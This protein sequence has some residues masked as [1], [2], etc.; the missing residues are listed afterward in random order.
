VKMLVKTMS[1]SGCR[2]PMRTETLVAQTRRHC[3][4]DLD[5]QGLKSVSACAPAAC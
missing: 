3:P 4:A 2:E 5:H 1:W